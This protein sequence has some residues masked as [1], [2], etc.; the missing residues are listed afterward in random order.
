M[1]NESKM[2]DPESKTLV[3]KSPKLSRISNGW[4]SI[5]WSLAFVE[6]QIVTYSCRYF[7]DHLCHRSRW[8]FRSR[9][10]FGMNNPN[11]DWT[12][13]L[14]SVSNPHFER[15]LG[16]SGWQWYANGR[17]CIFDC[18]LS[19][20]ISISWSLIKT[21]QITTIRRSGSPLQKQPSYGFF[22]FCYIPKASPL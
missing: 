1:G 11:L 5:H 2:T 4:Y 20:G 3:V 19:E 6:S 10:L 14:N 8:H 12:D 13:L 16:M 18:Q 9:T 22:K 21:V 17:A 7:V 15:L